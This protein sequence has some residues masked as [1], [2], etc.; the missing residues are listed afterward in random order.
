VR[1]PT[2]ALFFIESGHQLITKLRY[3]V[4]FGCCIHLDFIPPTPSVVST[5]LQQAASLRQ[6]P[7]GPVSRKRRCRCQILVT[8]DV[9]SSDSV[10]RQLDESRWNT[11]A[12][13]VALAPQVDSHYV[14]VC[15]TMTLPVIAALLGQLPKET[16]PRAELPAPRASRREVDTLFRNPRFSSFA[17]S[18]SQV[19]LRSR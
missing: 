7:F 10:S 8:Q 2:A 18:P 1:K 9:L 11:M 14:S 4:P 13:V 16:E 3:F 6:L 19:S 17:R 15:D 12:T 5:S